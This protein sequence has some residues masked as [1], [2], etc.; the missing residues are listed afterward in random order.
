[1]A[2]SGV[3][4][5]NSTPHTPPPGQE[6]PSG[7]SEG[8]GRSGDTGAQRQAQEMQDQA[9]VGQEGMSILRL[10]EQTVVRLRETRGS[11]HVEGGHS[12]F[13]LGAL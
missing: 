13:H 1:M 12:L 10:Q 8:R 6:I 2:A 9:G 7:V 11:P 3:T 5:P 4:R